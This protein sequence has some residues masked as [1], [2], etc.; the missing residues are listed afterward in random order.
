MTVRRRSIA[1]AGLCLF[2]LAAAP[3]GLFKD[4]LHGKWSATV[5]PDPG[6]PG[7]EHADTLTFTKGDLFS[8]ENLSKQGYDPAPYTDR[9]SPIGVADTWTVTLKDKAGDTAV[10][11][12]TEAGGQLTGSLVLTPKDGAP[13]SYTF[14]AERK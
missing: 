7:K 11:Q 12:G 4:A 13:A 9:P 5:V 8:S 14:K 3:A 2:A 6:S 1:L 10:W